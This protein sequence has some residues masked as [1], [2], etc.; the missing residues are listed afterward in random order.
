MHPTVDEWNVEESFF[1]LRSGSRRVTLTP[2]LRTSILDGRES[3]Y[4]TVL[5][6]SSSAHLSWFVADELRF[7]GGHW[8]VVDPRGRM[9]NGQTGVMLSGF[10]GLWD[11]LSCYDYR[12]ES[13]ESVSPDAAG[14][15]FIDVFTREQA[16]SA[17]RAGRVAERIVPALGG[18]PM[19]RWDIHE[20]LAQP[21]SPDAM[22]E[23]M[24]LQMPATERF[25]ARSAGG[26]SINITMS[27][28]RSG[29]LEQ[30]R[31]LIPV[32]DYDRPLGL[33]RRAPLGAHPAVTAALTELAERSR[34]TVAM[35]SYC[36]VQERDGSLGQFAELRRP[37]SPV[38]VLLGAATV[39]S[40]KLN[41]ARLAERYDVTAIGP[42]KISSV[43]IRF[44]GLD[45]LWS[46]MADLT[47]ELDEER[48]A[49]MLAHQLDTPW[50]RR[51]LG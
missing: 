51:E 18:G 28:T 44:S 3:A 21:W 20:P 39:K 11:P 41:V 17:T 7:G 35:V 33:P 26:A 1:V 42:K 8:V 9:Y 19:V 49:A 40:L 2:G 32:G 50:F 27:R 38:A 45:P 13:F 37:D 6:T 10:Q 12:L 29:L 46:Q 47:K 5:V 22:T 25:F 23:Q 24:R 14:A 30:T 48:L 16:T 34:V 4:K 43:L 36:Q 15:F 31:G